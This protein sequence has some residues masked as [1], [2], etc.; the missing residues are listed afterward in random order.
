MELGTLKLVSPLEFTPRP[1]LD[2]RQ[3]E[4]Q[5]TDLERQLAL[6]N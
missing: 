2:C 6:R 1:E 3:S 5:I 4:K